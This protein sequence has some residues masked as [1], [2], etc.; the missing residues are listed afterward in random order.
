MDLLGRNEGN[1][2]PFI[3]K[4]VVSCALDRKAHL[5]RAH[6][7]FA[8]PAFFWMPAQSRPTAVLHHGTCS[9]QSVL[10]RLGI[11]AADNILRNCCLAGTEGLMIQTS[12][13][14]LWRRR[15]NGVRSCDS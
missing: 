8:P 9:V 1:G 13:S 10:Q 7:K 5:L 6:K 2:E 15:V 14:S 3:R 12:E 4:Q 11:S